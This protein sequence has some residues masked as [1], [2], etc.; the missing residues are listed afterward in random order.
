MATYDRN[1]GDS[2]L[3]IGLVDG[4][5]IQSCEFSGKGCHCYQTSE[6]ASLP[7]VL[8]QYSG[9]QGSERVEDWSCLT[10]T[11]WLYSP[12]S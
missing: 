1:Q 12:V 8:A 10:H 5:R 6:F 11:G 7:M 4:E 2:V 3:R 9:M